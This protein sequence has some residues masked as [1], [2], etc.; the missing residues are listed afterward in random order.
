MS[1]IRRVYLIVSLLLILVSIL[2]FATGGQNLSPFGFLVVPSLIFIPLLVYEY[3]T[4]AKFIR[5][6]ILVLIISIAL[7]GLFYA[8]IFSLS[9][10]DT[11]QTCMDRLKSGQIAFSILY[12]GFA[13]RHYID[14][15]AIP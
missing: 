15:P 14:F 6:I 4:K 10:L 9:C 13:M 5:V 7:V 3:L 12:L 2:L 11:G 1:N 8:S